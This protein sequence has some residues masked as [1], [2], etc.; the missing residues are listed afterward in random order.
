MINQ[1]I[2]KQLLLLFIVACTSTIIATPKKNCKKEVFSKKEKINQEHP[3][4]SEAMWNILFP[5]RFGAKD[6]GGGN[7][8][9]DPKD[10]FYTYASFIE[11][12]NRMSK[13][14]AVF[15]RRCATNAYRITRIDK[16]SGS[17][18]VIRK[19]ADFEAPR[20]INK[21]I[22][23]EE[24]DYGNFL[25]EGNQETKKRELAAF[26]ANISHETTGGWPTA[27]GGRFSWGLHFR[28][29]PTT[30]LYASPDVNYPP[31]PGKSYKGRGPMQLSYNYNYGPAS[32]FIFGDKQV[33][34]DNPEKV[35]EDAALAFQTAIWFWMTPQYPK[36]S[37]HDVMVRNWQPTELD[38]SK[39]RVVGLGMTVNIINGGVEC[40]QGVEKPQVLDRIGYYERFAGIFNVGTDMDGVNDLSDCGCKDMERYGGDAA[41]ITTEP[42]AM[43]PSIS[44]TSP[45]NNQ[46]FKQPNFEVIPFTIEVD[47][48]NTTL[49][50]IVTTIN[51]QDFNGTSFSWTPSTYGTHSFNTKALF[52]NGL[53]AVANIKITVWDGVNLSC[54]DIPEWNNAIIYDKADNYIKYN[55]VVYR[56]KWYAD[57][58]NIPGGSN[59]WEKIKSCGGD[60]GGGTGTF[61]GKEK[62]D[63]NK[64]YY[65]GDQAYYESKIFRAKWW[66]QNNI[67]E[68]SQEWEFVENCSQLN[69]KQKQPF[70]AYPTIVVDKLYL[71][72]A[73]DIKESVKVQVF[74]YSGSLIK[75]FRTDNFQKGTY[76]FT[77]DVS[78]LKR[79]LYIYK[80][81]VGG[82][83]YNRKFIK[84]NNK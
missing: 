54:D 71:N 51:G 56:N 49:A 1:S 78:D 34:L 15:E 4:V 62:W 38:V 12:I 5:Y 43:K 9:L 77:Y 83:T 42:C 22:V 18:V 64:V 23:R 20:N 46:L 6:K 17:K 72:M 41:D 3:L 8:E 69:K 2:T 7:W 39:N 55:N 82:K 37:A 79:G 13:I 66:T 50:S 75:S 26:F 19:D 80:I 76:N 81:S 68:Q 65:K 36:P 61:C 67:P 74:D 21:D 16:V 27:P 10:D 35:I 40:G 30:S 31:T 48:K 14:K 47:R 70:N 53:E 11:A 57:S 33:L 32:E 60:D 25:K 24:V 58:S 29:E 44:F 63:A 84:Y 45:K 59:V 52:Q 28:E 73:P